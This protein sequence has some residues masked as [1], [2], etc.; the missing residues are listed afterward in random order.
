MTIKTVWVVAVAIAN[1]LWSCGD[2]RNASA[3]FGDKLAASS[4]KFLNVDAQSNALI[5]LNT[6]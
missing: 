6:F 5:K 1:H 2:N 3:H 4:A